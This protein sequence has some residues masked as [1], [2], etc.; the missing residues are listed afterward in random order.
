MSAT[1]AVTALARFVPESALDDAVQLLDE[2]QLDKL[3]LMAEEIR[4]ITDAVT[5]KPLADDADE[6][7]ATEL[8]VRG[9]AAMKELDALRKSRVGPLNEEV[10]AVN[11]LFKVLTDPGEALVGKG[12]KL[13]RMLLAY[14]QVKQARVRRQ[15]EEARRQQ[16]EA[17]QA[18]E[19]ALIAASEA[20]TA[21]AREEAMAQAEAAS[22]AQATATLAE[23]LAMPVGVRTDSGSAGARKVWKFE[24][25]DAL[26][27]PRAYCAPDERQIRAAVASGVREIAGVNIFEDEALTVRPG[28]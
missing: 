11:A 9:V 12:G 25:V 22:V 8:L 4:S 26:K 2:R 18:E 24:I 27:V 20:K 16:V 19:A 14:R 5:A 28:R 10:K 6:G 1:P 21:E 23:P 17:A 7:R 15:Q 13:E 3:V